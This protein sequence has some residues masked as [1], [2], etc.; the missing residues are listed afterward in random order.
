[1]YC[2]QCE[3]TYNGTGCL[4]VGV[5]G[6]D[7]DTAALQDLLVQVGKRVARCAHAAR[8]SGGS[9]READLFVLQALFA[10]GTNVNFDPSRLEPL[11]REGA[12][13]AGWKP[14]RGRV[15]LLGDA[16]GASVTTRITRLGGG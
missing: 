1:M 9:T 2:Y 6:K 14:G 12:V 16:R 13:L 11:I 8:Q 7:G 5:C 10:T 4:D 3:Q 15:G